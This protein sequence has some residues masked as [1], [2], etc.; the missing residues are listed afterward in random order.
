MIDITRVYG[1]GTKTF[2]SGFLAQFE[3]L[4]EQREIAKWL[5]NFKQKMPPGRMVRKNPTN[6]GRMDGQ[7]HITVSPKGN[8][9]TITTPF[10]GTVIVLTRIPGKTE[11]R[12]DVNFG[13]R[14]ARKRAQPW[15]QL[16]E[17]GLPTPNWTVEYTV[18]GN[19]AA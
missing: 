11:I 17:K 15:L 1:V 4:P 12:M 5:E 7:V 2:I 10:S 19:S 13:P 3:S 6:N 8:R 9:A 14:G 18:R 16:A